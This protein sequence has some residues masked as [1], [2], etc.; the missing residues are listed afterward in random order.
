MKTLPLLGG[1]EEALSFILTGD[2]DEAGQKTKAGVI[3]DVSA[4]V[5]AELKRQ[6][7]SDGNWDYLEP[8]AFEIAEHIQNIDLR[9]MHIMEG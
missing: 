5:I 9:S 3:E 4:A 1:M 8:H 7:L 6:K 2:N